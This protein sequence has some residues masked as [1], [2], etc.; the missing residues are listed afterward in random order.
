MKYIKMFEDSQWENENEGGSDFERIVPKRK[1]DEDFEIKAESIANLILNCPEYSRLK[2]LALRVEMNVEFGPGEG[3]IDYNNELEK[4]FPGL[5]LNQ[6]QL[7]NTGAKVPF[8]G[9]MKKIGVNSDNTEDIYLPMYIAQK[10]QE[11]GY[12]Y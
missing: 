3:P 2:E 6:Y 9:R 10:V 7:V 11:P 5:D 4:C 8:Y 12:K 1:I